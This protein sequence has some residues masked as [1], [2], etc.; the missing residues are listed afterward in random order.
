MNRVL[1]LLAARNAA[2]SAFERKGVL[3]KAEIGVMVGLRAGH[4]QSQRL[5]GCD[6]C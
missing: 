1:V 4:H 3:V 2:D 5:F 6:S